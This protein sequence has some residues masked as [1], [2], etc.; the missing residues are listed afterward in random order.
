MAV[1]FVLIAFIIRYHLVQS[2]LKQQAGLK[3][4]ISS[5]IFISI[6]IVRRMSNVDLI[7]SCS[8]DIT[9]IKVRNTNVTLGPGEMTRTRLSVCMTDGR[10][11]SAIHRIFYLTT[12]DNDDV[13]K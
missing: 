1:S 12:F 11:Q 4:C 13:T 9:N 8:F 5:T 6:M 2:T 7:L 3:F 10:Q